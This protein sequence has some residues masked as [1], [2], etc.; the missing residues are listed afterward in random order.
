M[1]GCIKLEISTRSKNRHFTFLFSGT[2]LIN[3][4]LTISLY[5]NSTK[6]ESSK[7]KPCIENCKKIM[8]QCTNIT[9]VENE[10]TLCYESWRSCINK[11]SCEKEWHKKD[12]SCLNKCDTESLLCDQISARTYFLAFKCTNQKIKCQK[13]C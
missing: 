12:K 1:F 13:T 3:L 9:N 6:T 8:K 4:W 10:L 5:P 2:M 7:P 11:S